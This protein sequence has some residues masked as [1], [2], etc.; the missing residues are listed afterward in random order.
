MGGGEGWSQAQ[1]RQNMQETR[2]RDPNRSELGTRASNMQD[3][4]KGHTRTEAML[5][6]FI[7]ISKQDSPWEI[8]P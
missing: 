8:I 6:F 3:P 4:C 1:G 5:K 2:L 7:S